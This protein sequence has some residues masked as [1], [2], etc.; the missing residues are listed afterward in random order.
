MLWHRRRHRCKCGWLAKLCFIAGIATLV[1]SSANEVVNVAV[2]DDGS[3]DKSFTQQHRDGAATVSTTAGGDSKSPAS[4]PEELQ[5]GRPKAGRRRRARSTRGFEIPRDTGPPSPE[6][7]KNL[8]SVDDELGVR[9]EDISGSDSGGA[10]KKR[11]P[12]KNP[13]SPAAKSV[14]ETLPQ[15]TTLSSDTGILKSKANEKTA[16]GVGVGVGAGPGASSLSSSP[17]PPSSSSS[18]SKQ[19][20]RR[21][22]KPRKSKRSHFGFELPPDFTTSGDE[23]DA[24]NG[25]GTID[26]GA[27]DVLMANIL[28]AVIAVVVVL[29]FAV[30]GL[31]QARKASSDV[32][33]RS[34]GVLD[35]REERAH[36]LASQFTL[37]ASV[38]SDAVAVG[39]GV[40]M[41]LKFES[42]CRQ[43]A[44]CCFLHR[45]NG[46]GGRQD[47]INAN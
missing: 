13:K 23:D 38:S 27:V 33:L 1:S 22:K 44:A 20:F 2:G 14:S 47:A 35:V 32:H 31:V 21:S 26:A 6:N 11:N 16:A 7:E 28:V 24:A 4:A 46:N 9:N 8:E 18:S 36:I 5:F 12:G 45:I 40:C 34:R 30:I 37:K 25:A 42:A 41:M 10:P 15:A 43:V 19:D 29:V 3:V 39:G 17:P